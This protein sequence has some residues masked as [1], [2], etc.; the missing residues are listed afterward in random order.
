MRQQRELAG[1]IVDFWNGTSWLGFR[2]GPD[3][4]KM[5]TN[6]KLLL[7]FSILRFS[8]KKENEEISVQK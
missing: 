7:L 2:S 8:V 5:T 1:A 3:G 6:K 4:Y